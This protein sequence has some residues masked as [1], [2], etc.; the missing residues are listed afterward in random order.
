MKLLIGL[1]NPGSDYLWTRHNLGFIALD[2]LAIKLGA[3]WLDKPK[4]DAAVAEVELA[5]EKTLMVKPQTFYNKS[6][7]ALQKIAS[8]YKVAN[9]DILVLADDFDLPFGEIRYREHGSAGGNNGLS[10]IIS[11]M[12]E[13]VKRIRIGTDSAARKTLGDTDFV[14]GKLTDSERAELP[15]ILPRIVEKITENL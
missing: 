15:A 7:E 1:G 6:G 5:G 11:H 9:Y 13:N 8:F 3:A 2:F 14:L 4:W 10:S 12:G